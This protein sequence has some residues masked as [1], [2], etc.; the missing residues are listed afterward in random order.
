VVSIG[1][2]IERQLYPTNAKYSL[3]LNNIPVDITCRSKDSTEFNKTFALEVESLKRITD[4]LEEELG[5]S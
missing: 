1:A 3:E 2:L 4:A 5:M